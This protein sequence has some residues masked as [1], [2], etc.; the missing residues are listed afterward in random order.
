MHKLF[1]VLILFLIPM[2]PQRKQISGNEHMKGKDLIKTVLLWNER[3]QYT[4]KTI[5]SEYKVY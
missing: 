4:F 5:C 1:L 3:L 2:T